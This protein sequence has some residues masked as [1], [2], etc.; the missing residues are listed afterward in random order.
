[1]PKY[2]HPDVLDNGLNNIKTNADNLHLIKNY[3]AADS[4]ATVVGN[5]VASAATVSGDYV[6]GNQGVNGRQL[7]TPAKAPS[8]SA[9]STGGDDLHIA[10]VDSVGL[11]VLAV[12]DETSDQVITS[13]NAVNIPTLNLKM[14]QPV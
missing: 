3:A 2:F 14:N 12:T 10:Y 5:S 1:M 13:G 6:L 11:K 9:S 4:Y 7:A 8:A